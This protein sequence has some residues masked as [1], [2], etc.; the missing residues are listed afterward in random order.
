MD[1]LAKKYINKLIIIIII[2]AVLERW[3]LVDVRL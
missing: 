1:C 3:P 2:T